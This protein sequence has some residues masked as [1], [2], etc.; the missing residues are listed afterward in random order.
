N[1]IIRHQPWTGS[2]K[3]KRILAMRFQALGDLMITL[4]YL[5]S[6]TK[7]MPALQIDLLT[8]TNVSEIPKN[9][10]LFE[11]VYSISGRSGKVQLLFSLLLL[12]RLLL[13]KYDVVVDLQNHRVSRIIRKL[14]NAKAWSEFDR[15]SRILAGERTR[16]TI[17]SL[18]ISN[19]FISTNLELR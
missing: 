18:Q 19:S 6:L 4:P 17:D 10:K 8:R 12:P 2:R 11:K 5:Q 16:L 1:T 15:S 14:L 3:P 9:L 7:L 13:N